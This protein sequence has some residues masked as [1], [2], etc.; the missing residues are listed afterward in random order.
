[1]RFLSKR[2]AAMI[3]G[4]SGALAL[5]CVSGAAAQDPGRGWAAQITPYVWATAVGGTIRPFA[6]APAVDIDESFSEI[7]ENLDAAFFIAGFARYDRF[8][9]QGDF[10]Y[11]ASSRDGV[12][13]PGI[14]AEGELTQTSL[15]F[16]AGYRVAAEETATLD[17]L[18]GARAWDIEG[19]VA[20]PLAGLAVSAEESF[21]DPILAARAN[22]TLAPDWSLLAY[23][24]FGGFGA[25][26]DFTF[27]I[28][29]TV[30]YA[31]TDSLFLSAGYRY[32]AVD[33]DDG[34]TRLDVSLSGPLI[35]ATWRF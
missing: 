2:L 34:G 25:G 32:L 29:A 14:P 26:S 9:F 30:N 10:S 19:S 1:M 16:A 24:D 6:G 33:Y 11:A 20:V 31:L 27:Q 3:A 28:V 15:T 21:V 18:A 17:L 7:L 13:P 12:I 22:I 4:L 5:V 8:V 23:A 35:G